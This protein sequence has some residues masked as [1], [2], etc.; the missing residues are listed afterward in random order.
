[1]GIISG[2]P[3]RFVR[4]PAKKDILLPKTSS[5]VRGFRPNGTAVR[6]DF[7]CHTPGLGSATSPSS[8]LISL[9]VSPAPVDP[10]MQSAGQRD[11]RSAHFPT[12]RMNHARC[13]STPD[14]RIPTSRSADLSLFESRTESIDLF[15]SPGV[16][17]GPQR[18]PTNEEQGFLCL[19]IRTSRPARLSG[20]PE[21]TLTR[22]RGK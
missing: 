3:K 14:S 2:D 16:R 18:T 19:T 10:S 12:V 8:C 11:R 4:S 7:P 15:L 5:P 13:V 1:M 9:L 6:G 22:R 21:K 17:L 20:R